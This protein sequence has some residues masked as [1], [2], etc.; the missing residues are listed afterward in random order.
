MYF[1][2]FR[3]PAPAGIPPEVIY[4]VEHLISQILTTATPAFLQAALERGRLAQALFEELEFFGQVPKRYLPDM[5]NYL[6]KQER[7][8]GEAAKRVLKDPENATLREQ[9]S[10]PLSTPSV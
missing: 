2:V 10:R 6:M 7:S 9:L 4:T 8:L 5:E 1:Q 3:Q